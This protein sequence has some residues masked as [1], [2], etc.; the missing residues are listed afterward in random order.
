METWG[1]NNVFK[2]TTDIT[3]NISNSK[4]AFLDTLDNFLNLFLLSW[5]HQVVSS[6]YFGDGFQTIANTNPVGHHDSFITP[7]ITKDF[8]KQIMT[9]LGKLSVNNIV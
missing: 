9:S 2:H 7:I 1:F 5:F 8:C 4:F 3:I 6:I